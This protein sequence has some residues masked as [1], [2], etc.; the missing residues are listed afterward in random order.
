MRQKGQLEREKENE[1]KKERKERER[2]RRRVS[3][4]QRE[5]DKRKGKFSALEVAV[6]AALSFTSI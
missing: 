2:K 5:I 4:R 3:N 1:K 6:W